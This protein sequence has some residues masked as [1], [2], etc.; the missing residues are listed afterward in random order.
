[1]YIYLRTNKTLIYNSLYEFDN[2]GKNLNHKK[3]QYNWSME[4]FSGRAKPI[5]IIG[6]PNQ[7]P[8]NWSS[9][10]YLHAL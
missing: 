1:M 6:F 5:W 8:D 2:C 7:F 9:A 3:M 4:M 10:I